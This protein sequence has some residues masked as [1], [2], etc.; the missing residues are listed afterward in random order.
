MVKRSSQVHLTSE[1]TNIA[2]DLLLLLGTEG[3]ELIS[4]LRQYWTHWW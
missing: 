4:V 1:L 2:V 3:A